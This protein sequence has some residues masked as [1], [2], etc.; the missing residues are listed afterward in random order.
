MCQNRGAGACQAVFVFCNVFIIAYAQTIVTPN[1]GVKPN[2]YSVISSHMNVTFTSTSFGDSVRQ[3]PSC[4]KRESE[5]DMTPNVLSF[6]RCHFH[7]RYAPAPKADR[8][9][10][11]SVIRREPWYMTAVNTVDT[12]LF[13][14]TVPREES[15]LSTVA[16]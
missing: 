4:D 16:S 7:C 3:N 12:A 2:F 11:I 10:V 5:A 1:Y 14:N 8:S 6:S 15:I 13:L 9:A